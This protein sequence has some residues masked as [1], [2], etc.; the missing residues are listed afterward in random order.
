MGNKGR[1]KKSGTNK[2]KRILVNES[3]PD[4]DNNPPIFSLQLVQDNKK[5][6][7]SELT[8]E[9]KASFS[10]T[11]Y[12]RRNISWKE[13]KC[14]DRHGLGFEKINR[15]CIK[16]PIPSFLSDD[17]THFLAFRYNGMKAMLGYRKKDIFFILWFD[18]DFTLYN[19]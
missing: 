3:P 9:D 16:A 15:S 18:P 12:K 14:K 4:Y 13:L 2:G 8:K 1:F 19:H 7:F 11:L 10:N 5:Y 6:G 17:V